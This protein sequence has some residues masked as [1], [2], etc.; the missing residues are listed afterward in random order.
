MPGQES[1]RLIPLF[2]RRWAVPVLAELHRSRGAKFITLVNRLAVSR[3]S[4]H[5]TL[6]ELVELGWVRR[7]PGHGHPLRP[8]YVLSRK[9]SELAPWCARIMAMLSRLGI[10]EVALRK[11]SLPVLLSLGHGRERFSEIRQSLPGLTPRSLTLAL[12][13]LRQIDLISR[14]VSDGYPPS[15]RYRP[16]RRG[17][18][19][20][21]LIDALV[22]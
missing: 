7:N 2:H 8:E 5:H 1:A 12:K 4:L 3:D 11:W 16:T 14:L 13:Q 9:G 18:R 20:S 15:S 17:R 19:L 22:P 6:R 10:E 21:V